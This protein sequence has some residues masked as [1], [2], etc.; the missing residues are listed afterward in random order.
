[1]E[2]PEEDCPMAVIDNQ[3]QRQSR[4]RLELQG[5]ALGAEVVYDL[6]VAF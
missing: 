6:G 4:D 5:L 3:L 1:M 2:Q